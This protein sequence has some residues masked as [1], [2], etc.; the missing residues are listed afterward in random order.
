MSRIHALFA[1]ALRI[2]V[3]RITDEST[4]DNT[5]EWDSLGGMNIVSL[6][7]DELDIEFSTKEM[8]QMK[9][10]AAAREILRAKGVEDS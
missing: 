10:V 9:S 5:P 7:E 6:L 3:E 8:M 4:P 1:E 2:P